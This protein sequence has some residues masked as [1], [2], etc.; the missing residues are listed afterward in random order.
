MNADALRSPTL[1]YNP[2]ILKWAREWRGRSVQEAAQKVNVDEEKLLAWESGSLVPTVR[3]ARILADFYNRSFLEFFLSRI[4]N[5][6]ETKL[7]PDFRLYKLSSDP[8][9]DREIKAI[10][11]WAEETRQGAL[12]LFRLLG[13]DIPAVPAEFNANTDNSPELAAA[14]ARRLCGYS[15]DEQIALGSG[16]RNRVAKDIRKAIERLGVLVLKDSSLGK[17]GVRGITLF[18]DPLPVVV[19]GTEA[20]TAQAFTL[21]HELGH[22]ALQQSAISG[23]PTARETA[24]KAERSERWCDEFAGAFLIPEAALGKMWAKPN[25]PNPEISDHELQRLAN[26]FSVS[27]HAMLIRLVHLRYVNPQYYW[28]HKRP[29]FLKQ[30]AEFKG[31]G[32]AAYYGT[33]YRNSYGDTYTALVLEAWGTGQITNHTAAE[34]MGIKNLTHLFDIRDK[35][36][37]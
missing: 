26:Q 17:Y 34:L 3:Q 12:E 24:S 35:F 28:D 16:E 2:H 9:G 20:P 5:V 30:E 14:E 21:A 4:P 31:G 10:Q 8:R 23:P 36:A 18:A 32:K 7:A 15:V 37:A 27:R 33:R 1:P 11:D 6:V 13:E 25:R 22:I 19:F 29:E